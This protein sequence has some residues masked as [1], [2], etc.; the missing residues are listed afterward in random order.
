MKFKIIIFIFFVACTP[1]NNQIEKQSFSSKGFAYIYNEEDYKK[2]VIMK[3]FNNE[4]IV[5]S[6]QYLKIGTLLK[7]INPENKKFINVKIIK[8]SKYPEFYKIL[9]TNE[10]ANKLSLNRSIPFVE[11]YEIKKNKSFIAGKAKMF[12]EEKK[13]NS[14]APVTLVKIDNISK[15]KK[16]NKLKIYKFSINIAN[17][18]SLE[19]AKMLKKKLINDMPNYNTKK[20]FIQKKKKNMYKLISG[21]YK[22]VNSLKNDYIVLKKYGFEDLDINLNE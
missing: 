18:Y 12:S 22:A 10:I 7:I 1:S 5:A 19:S 20:L 13:V 8:K 17:F 9:I 15:E 6:H 2:K 3:K 11:I 4:E 16:T 14:K 21:P